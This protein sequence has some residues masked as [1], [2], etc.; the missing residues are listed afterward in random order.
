[1]P[2]W[3]SNQKVAALYYGASLLLISLFP[4]ICQLAQDQNLPP[5][6]PSARLAINLILLNL[7]AAYVWLI[8]PK[9][10]M[11]VPNVFWL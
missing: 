6:N 9:K 10:D 5:L 8:C 7:G 11:T 3:I 1:M 4:F 2:K